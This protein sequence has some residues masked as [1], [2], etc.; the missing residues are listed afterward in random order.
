MDHL[1]ACDLHWHISVAR[2]AFVVDVKIDAQHH[3]QRLIGWWVRRRSCCR[4][5]LLS[6]CCASSQLVRP[7]FVTERGGRCVQAFKSDL[8]DEAEALVVAVRASEVAL[9]QT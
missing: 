7:A 4:P 9:A 3:V 5:S 6:R 2:R 8:L 1:T